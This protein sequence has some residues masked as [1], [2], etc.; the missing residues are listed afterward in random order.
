MPLMKKTEMPASNNVLNSFMTHYFF[1][2]PITI[3]CKNN[4]SFP[5]KMLFF[6]CY[7]DHN[8]TLYLTRA[9]IIHHFLQGAAFVFLEHLSEFATHATLPLLSKH[10]DEISQRFHQSHR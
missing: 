4:A 5:C 10:C 7:H 2:L 8:L 9:E 3:F 6:S 1:E